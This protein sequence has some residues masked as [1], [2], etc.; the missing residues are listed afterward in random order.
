[1]SEFNET[2]QPLALNQLPIVD[3]DL[4]RELADKKVGENPGLGSQVV[5]GTP[6]IQKVNDKLVWVVPLEHSGFFKWLK[7]MDGSAGY[8]VVA[9]ND[10]SD[11]TLVTDHKIK[12]QANA[13][14]LDDLNRHVRLFGGGLFM[15][16]TDYSFELDD[17]GVPYWVLTT[18]KNRWLFNLPEADGVLIVNATTGETN[19]YTIDT[20][21][22]WVDRVQPESF[23]MQQINNQGQYVH[24]IFNFSNQDKFR[25]SR[26]DIIIYNGAR[27]YLFTGLTSVG[28]DESA[29]GFI[30]VDM[31]TKESF[32]YQMSGA[33]EV[34]AQSSAEGKV[35]QFGYRASF[36]HD[37][38]S[39]RTAHLLYDPEG[40]CR[41][42]QAV[43]L[44]VRC[45][46]YQRGHRRD[47]RQRPAGLPPDARKLRRHPDRPDGQE[48]EGHRAQDRLGKPGGTASPTRLFW[49]KNPICCSP[50]P[51][52]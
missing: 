14:I 24:G 25:P 4:A 11:V 51:M 26:G 3:K 41:A 18:Y 49:K 29:I 19:R 20:I 15:G 21:P 50:C 42:D 16:L 45:Q 10:V 1:M 35:Q 7:N 39:G 9:A 23:V 8:I 33:T 52:I 6:V 32:L 47:H 2:V 17:D 22:E 46:L 13:Y 43:C 28:S 37:H 36:P 12:Y 48:R 30:L 38:Q 5:L 31:V 27:C 40:Q 34:A 44:R